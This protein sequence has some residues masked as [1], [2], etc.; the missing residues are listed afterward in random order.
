[1][2]KAT[3]TDRAYEKELQDLRQRLLLMA[4]RV[5][6]MIDASIRALVDR[7]SDL[8]QQTIL[9][10]RDVDRDERELDE[11]C[12]VILAKRQPMASDLRFIT[13][14]LKMV[15]D[16]ERIGDLA[17][18]IC[19]RALDLNAEPS[20]KPYE[21]VPRMAAIVQSMVRGAIDSFVSSDT[22]GAL[23]VI[24]RDDEVDELY[25][26]I[27]RDLLALMIRDP[28]VVER[29]I[30]IQSVAKFLE[31]I[32][33]HS[34]N[35]AEEVVFVVKGKDVRHPGTIGGGGEPCGSDEDPTARGERDVT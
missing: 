17:V 34:T 8:A 24:A 2:T 11:H 3:H 18:N 29:G 20:L 6:D 26:V 32:G 30:H 16:L 22:E 25:H 7:D 19:E 13:L 5:E 9:A 31:R 15:T 23:A 1:M 4:G 21:D 14:A 35:L 27:F 10:D 12:L 33:D 28:G